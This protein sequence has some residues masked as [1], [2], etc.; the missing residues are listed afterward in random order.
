MV[1]ETDEDRDKSNEARSRG[2]STLAADD[3]TRLRAARGGSAVRTAASSGAG[4]LAHVLRLAMAGGHAVERAGRLLQAT[5]VTLLGV[6]RRTPADIDG[7]TSH[8]RYEVMKLLDFVTLRNYWLYQVGLSSALAQFTS[9]S[10]LEAGMLHCR[11]MIEFSRFQLAARSTR[12]T[13]CLVGRCPT[14]SRLMA[15]R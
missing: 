8:V 11:N 14:S 2:L 12:G 3:P 7:M 6:S 1:R 9:E 13:T 5:C 4:D 10:L 15:R